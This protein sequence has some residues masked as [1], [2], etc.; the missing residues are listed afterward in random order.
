LWNPH[1]LFRKMVTEIYNPRTGKKLRLLGTPVK[2]SRGKTSIR[3]APPAQGENTGQILKELG[4]S[5][6][7][8]AELGRKGVVRVFRKSSKQEKDG[9]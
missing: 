5:Q 8:V 4:F 2:F 1:T 6:K 3:L 7:R 9:G